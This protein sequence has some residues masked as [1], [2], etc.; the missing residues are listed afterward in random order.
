MKWNRGTKQKY[1]MD[2]REVF[3]KEKAACLPAHRPRDCAIDLFPNT[4]PPK[5]RVYPLSLPET[6]AMEDYIEKALALGHIRPST[7]PPAASF[8]FVWKKDGGLHPC[9]DYRSLNTV[10][11]R[12]PYLLPLVPATLEQLWGAKYFTK[13]DLCS[14][15]NL[16]RI[17][18]GNECK[19]AFH[20]TCGHYEYLVMPFG[21]TN[22]PAMFQS[23][24]NEVFQD[25]LNRNVIA[26]IDDILIYSTSFDEHVRH[27][28]VVLACLQRHQLYVK[29][30]KCEFHRA[31]IKFLGYMISQQGVKMDLSKVHAVTEW[32]E[33]TMVKEL[34]RFLGFANF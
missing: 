31:T 19:I 25:M 17:R 22:A 28:Q 6:K 8:F 7:S 4:V 14:V 15:Y 30:E 20:T 13:L 3:R 26:Y 32:P 16:I 10:T 27:I 18:D 21:L 12:Y 5:S 23:L 24:I 11:I 2:Q 29:L 33:P 1:Y 9:I 34:Q